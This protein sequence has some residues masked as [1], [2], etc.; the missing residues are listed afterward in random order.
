MAVYDLEEQEQLAELKTWWTQHGN[1]VTSLFLV[2]ALS[3]AG[4][5]AW[6]WW[7]RDQAAQAS[8]VYGGLQLADRKS[9]RLNSSHPRLSRMP[10][11][12]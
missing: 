11:S 6:N 7:Q 9:T 1:F 10:S 4:W 5:Q 12:A 3:V 2:V 8:A